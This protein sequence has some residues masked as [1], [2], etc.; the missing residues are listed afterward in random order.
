ML[1]YQTDNKMHVSQSYNYYLILKNTDISDS[2]MTF[3]LSL[4]LFS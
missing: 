2:N 4:Q 1:E 3:S